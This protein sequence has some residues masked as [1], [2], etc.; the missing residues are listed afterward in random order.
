MPA[1]D[2]QRGLYGLPPSN[3]RGLATATCIIQ[4]IPYL[5]L[6]F[7]YT[8]L[9]PI[10]IGM[11]QSSV[12]QLAKTSA[13]TSP[14]TTLTIQPAAPVMPGWLLAII[15]GCCLFPVMIAILAAMLLPALAAAKRKAQ[16]ITSV[17]HLKEIGLAF[18]IWEGNHQ[19][20]YPFNLTQTQGGVKELCETDTDG[21][22]K[23]P[24]PIFMVMSNELVSPSILV[25][26]DDP[27]KQPAPDFSSLTANNISYLL[28][29]GPDVNDRHPQEILAVDPINGVVLYCDGS[30][31][32]DH[33]YK[34]NLRNH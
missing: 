25:C 10:Y 2:E 29:T 31:A 20:Q 21:F 34:S 7:G 15:L 27:D 17:N 26:P 8:I 14:N 6:L 30:V 13:T 9:M 22:E 18:R 32:I 12:N 5:N 11:M 4:V 24:A 19:D 23:N 1:V 3:L 33:N 28:R 16:V